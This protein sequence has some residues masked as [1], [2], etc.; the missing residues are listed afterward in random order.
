VRPAGILHLLRLQR[1]NR[2][3]ATSRRT[4]LGRLPA[5]DAWPDR[6][7][8]DRHADGHDDRHGRARPRRVSEPSRLEAPL[9]NRR[10]RAFVDVLARTPDEADDLHVTTFIDEYFGDLHSAKTIQ[11]DA[12]QIRRDVKDLF[13]RI[14]DAADAAGARGRDAAS[15]RR[16]RGNRQ[17]RRYSTRVATAA[18]QC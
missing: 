18:Y 10:D 1:L 3:G 4:R 15:W 8:P 9:S 12:R 2:S 17:V 13:R 7:F 14:R 6:P 11:S 5:E 16:A